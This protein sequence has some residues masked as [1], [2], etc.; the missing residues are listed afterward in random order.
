MHESSGVQQL[1]H[2][3]LGNDKVISLFK[4]RKGVR[5]MNMHFSMVLCKNLYNFTLGKPFFAVIDL[6]ALIVHLKI[7][8]HN[9]YD[10][11]ITFQANLSRAHSMGH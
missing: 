11:P 5:M 4:I 10:E 3:Y 7:K 9:I 6:V 1:S 2:S 8:Y